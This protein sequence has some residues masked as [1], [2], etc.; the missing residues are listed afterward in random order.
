[1]IAASLRKFEDE[2]TN[3]EGRLNVISAAP[4]EAGIDENDF[5]KHVD[6]IYP[7]GGKKMK[8]KQE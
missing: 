6:K 8:T 2:E 5:K 4:K 7:I 3:K 1:M